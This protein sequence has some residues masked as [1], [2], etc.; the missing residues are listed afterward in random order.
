MAKNNDITTAQAFERLLNRPDQWRRTGRPMQQRLNFL[1]KLKNGINV[2]TDTKE[3]IL[4]EAGY[5]VKQQ[6]LWN[7][8]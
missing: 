7:E 4:A 1:D 5:T 2:T 6:T 3:K 8:P